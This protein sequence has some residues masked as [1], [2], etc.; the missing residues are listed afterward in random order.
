MDKG[1]ENLEHIEALLALALDRP[2]LP[3]GGPP[4]LAE[5]A[6]WTEGTLDPDQAARVK[7]YVARDPASYDLWRQYSEARAQLEQEPADAPG[8]LHKVYSWWAAIRAFGSQLATGWATWHRRFPPLRQAAGAFATISLVAAMVYQAV[9][10]DPISAGVDRG[11]ANRLHTGAPSLDFWEW[12]QYQTRGDSTVGRGAPPDP[13]A[14]AQKTAFQ[15]GLRMAIL[16]LAD[17]NSGWV[18]IAGSLSAQPAP[19]PKGQTGRC[20]QIQKAMQ[21]LGRWSF[22]LLDAC[23]QT[24]AHESQSEEQLFWSAQTELAKQFE[25]LLK[26]LEPADPFTHLAHA[27]LKEFA[28]Q[29]GTQEGRRAGVCSPVLDLISIGVNN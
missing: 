10:Y 25:V 13:L 16:A 5:I 17:G 14:E 11:F 3:Q 12:D 20:E 29:A 18:R 23:S 19:C 26:G 1:N 27:H 22:L 4:S 15:S 6:A 8:A 24:L 7:A 21:S 9:L 28:G 2:E